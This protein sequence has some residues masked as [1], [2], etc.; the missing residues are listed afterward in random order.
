[1]VPSG[2]VIETLTG[3]PTSN[4]DVEADV[5][6]PLPFG[7]GSVDTVIARHVL[8]HL[9][10]PILTLK[11]WKAVLKREGRLIIAVPNSAIHESI[12]MNIEHVHAWDMDSMRSLL[13]TV[14]MTV[15]T[16]FPSE[17][18]ISFISVAEKP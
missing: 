14:G 8:E 12:P 13:E 7:H 15:I 17:N 1:M 9:I 4:A 2:T 18:N 5:S 16:Q 11:R 3:K 6:E 10:D